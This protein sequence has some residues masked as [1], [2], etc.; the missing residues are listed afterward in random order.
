MYNLLKR[1]LSKEEL[2]G[3]SGI[4][5]IEDGDGYVLF[6]EYHIRNNGDSYTLTNFD[7][8]LKKEFYSLRNAVIWATLDKR[9][10]VRQAAH[11]LNL[12]RMLSGAT[13]NAELHKHLSEK[14]KD[15][16]KRTLYQAKL[17]E[18][19]T[20]KKWIVQQLNDYAKEVKQWQFKQ[21][22][23]AKK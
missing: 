15:F 7:T 11:V 23:E 3:L 20:K 1:L 2:S 10:R 12:D 22:A 9:Q 18:D 16:D 17:Q 5:V 14:T 6:N 19:K 8:Y 4:V 21:F 13:A